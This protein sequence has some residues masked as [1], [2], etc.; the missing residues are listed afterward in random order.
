VLQENIKK[1]EEMVN[2]DWW[3]DWMEEAFLEGQ[4]KE[5]K[6]ET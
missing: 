6:L 3:E 5:K 1:T 2:L 4:R